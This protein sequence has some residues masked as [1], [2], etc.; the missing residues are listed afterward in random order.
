MD[1]DKFENYIALYKKLIVYAKDVLKECGW[2]EKF[3]YKIREP[4]NDEFLPF[5]HQA[6]TI[7]AESLGNDSPFYAYIVNNSSITYPGRMFGYIY[8][9]NLIP[10][11][12]TFKKMAIFQTEG[13]S[14]TIIPQKL[15]TIDTFKDLK[16]QSITIKFIDGINV[17]ISSGDLKYKANYK[18][19]GFEDSR[20]LKP[21]T[22]WEFLK[23]LARNNGSISW[24]NKE[25][26]PIIK[27]H[28]QLLSKKLQIF[29]QINE[30]PFYP[31]QKEKAYRIKI[32]LIPD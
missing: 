14:K 13:K 15:F 23:I 26:N 17:L 28:K 24:D 32:N 11:Y 29:F 9:K 4:T 25:A 31:Y 12:N 19:M 18:D 6:K 10:A 3:E 27:K 30:P 21:N 20:K 7:V 2:I 16:W 22:Q 8:K 5:I 1:K